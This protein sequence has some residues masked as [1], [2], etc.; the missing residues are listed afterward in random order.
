MYEALGSITSIRNKTMEK[1]RSGTRSEELEV[2]EKRV[3]RNV[4][5]VK[6]PLSKLREG[7]VEKLG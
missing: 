4:S 1:H 5:G 7:E 6:W 3:V 2:V